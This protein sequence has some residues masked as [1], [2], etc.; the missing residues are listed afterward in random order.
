MTEKLIVLEGVDPA[1][2]Y[3]LYDVNLEK[4]KDKISETQS[5][6]PRFDPQNHGRRERNQPV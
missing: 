4:N 1:E 3:G 6:R 2:F 5:H